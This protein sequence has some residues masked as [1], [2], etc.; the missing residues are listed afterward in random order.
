MVWDLRKRLAT[1]EISGEGCT[2]KDHMKCRISKL[3]TRP[4]EAL[5]QYMRVEAIRF[6][7]VVRGLCMK[8]A[9]LKSMRL[10]ARL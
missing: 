1:Q 10:E 3:N 9:T 6:T 5:A 8:A 2:G 4:I 7:R